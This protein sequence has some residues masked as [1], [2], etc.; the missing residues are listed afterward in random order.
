VDLH[1]WADGPERIVLIDTETEKGDE[2]QWWGRLRSIGSTCFLPTGHAGR[3][4]WTP[5]DEV[6]VTFLPLEETR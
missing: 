5:D 3:C 1:C 4:V 6:T 2:G